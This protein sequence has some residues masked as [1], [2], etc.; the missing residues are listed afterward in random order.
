MRRFGEHIS[1]SLY[2]YTSVKMRI[3]FT[4]NVQIQAIPQNCFKLS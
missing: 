4:E 2:C 3:A 1:P